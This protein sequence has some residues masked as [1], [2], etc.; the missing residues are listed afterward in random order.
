MKRSPRRLTLARRAILLV[1][2][3][4]AVFAVPAS[5]AAGTLT[6]VSWSVSNSQ[7]SATG[8]KYAFGFTTAT[9]GT[10]KYVTMTVP[11]GTAGAPS[12]AA[13]YGIGAGS[14][15]LA[16]TTLTYTVTSAASIASGTPIYIELD[17]LTNTGTA[18]SY[19]STVTTQDATPTDI[20]TASSQ[21]V[22]FGSGAVSSMV[23]VAKSTAFSIDTNA[24]NFVLDPSVNTSAT[25]A[26]TI[27]ISSNAN[28]GYTLGCKINQQPTGTA[29][30]AAYTAN[31]AAAA[32]WGAGVGIGKFG[33]ALAVTDN[34]ATTAPALAGALDATHFAGFTTAGETCGSSSGPTGNPTGATPATA[35]HSWVATVKSEADYKTPADTYSATITFTVTPS[36]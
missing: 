10:V 17:G 2:L 28:N 13:N 5:Q 21:S 15:G 6:S 8:V 31:A 19:T 11:A 34:G 36:Y 3:L 26:I 23:L 12:I 32:T 33:Y 18:G 14:V 9:T 20:D 29:S 27:G 24:F 25:K 16:G 7:T 1:P 4:V 35:A 22:S 30:L